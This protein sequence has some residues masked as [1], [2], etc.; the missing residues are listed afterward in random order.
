MEEEARLKALLEKLRIDATIQVFWLAS[1]QLQGYETIVNGRGMNSESGLIIHELLKDD[2]WWQELQ[3]LRTEAHEMSRS[4]ELASLEEMLNPTRRRGSSMSKSDGHHSLP[5]GLDVNDL[6][7]KSKQPTVST[8]AKLGLNFGIHTHQL[9]SSAFN[10]QE[11][12]D[13][14]DYSDEDG[15]SMDADFNDSLSTASDGE[16]EDLTTSRRDSAM[17][18][19]SRRKSYGDI[20]RRE[21]LLGGTKRKRTQKSGNTATTNSSGYG[22]IAPVTRPAITPAPPI[23]RA[24]SSTGLLSVASE[25]GDSTPTT[26][27]APSR[28]TFSRHSSTGRFTSKPTPETTMVV[29]EGTG[30]RMTFSTEEEPA[31]ALPRRPPFSR[32]VSVGRYSSRPVPE[33]KV[34]NEDEFGPRLTFAEPEASASEPLLKSR[35]NSTSRN[36]ESLNTQF[37]VPELLESYSPGPRADE[38]IRSLYSTQSIPLSFNDLPSRAQHLIINE[39]MRQHSNETAIILTTLPIPEEGTCKSEEA[40]LRYLT[41]IEVLCHEL[42]PVLLVLSNNMT[43]TA[44]L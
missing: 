23:Q 16:M 6:L 11:D 25:S 1:G 35:R 39:L 4:Q 17:S 24:Q 20:M 8:I 38:E 10:R 37:N 36:N 14:T 21:E 9:S 27:K 13:S 5:R 22:T 15:E 12:E 43:V 42:P 2:D 32:N 29:E 33:T 26:T 30:P 40:G 28:P 19:V 41:D 34:E 18:F 44:S 31:T 3:N 7:D